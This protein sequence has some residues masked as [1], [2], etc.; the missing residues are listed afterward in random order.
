MCLKNQILVLQL[1]LNKKSLLGKYIVDNSMFL[2]TFCV[3][4]EHFIDKVAQNMDVT[5]SYLQFIYPGEISTLCLCLC[6]CMLFLFFL[7]ANYV[8]AQFICVFFSQAS[9][10]FRSCQF[11]GSESNFPS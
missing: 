3:S 8:V 11:P 2:S 1:N 10:Y 4:V 5:L 6:Y 9:I 7:L